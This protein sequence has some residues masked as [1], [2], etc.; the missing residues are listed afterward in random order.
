MDVIVLIREYLDADRSFVWRIF[1]EVV[2]AGNTLVSREHP[3]H[4]NNA[5]STESS[6]G[7]VFTVSA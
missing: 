3:F 5:E 7:D 6:K 1:H 2:A 4:A